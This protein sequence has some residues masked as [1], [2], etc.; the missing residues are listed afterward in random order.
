[1]YSGYFAG[2][3]PNPNEGNISW[4][5][6]LL[7]AIMGIFTAF[8]FKDELEDIEVES[9]RDIYANENTEKNKS[10]LPSDIFDKTKAERAAEEAARRAAERAARESR[11]FWNTDN[12]LD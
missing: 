9:M 5:G 12:T 3:A 6:H 10:F 7:G 4:E 2:I 8:Y 1:M 11:N